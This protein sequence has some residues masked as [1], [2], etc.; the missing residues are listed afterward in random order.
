MINIDNLVRPNIRSLKPYS[1]AR[2]EYTGHE[3]IYLDA[4]EN[5]YGTWNRYP[6]P[7]QADLKKALSL[8]KNIPL[9]NIFIGNGCDEVIDLALRIF[10]TPG[11]HKVIICPPT[12][13]MYE[14][15]AHINDLEI[16][17]IPLTEEFQLNIDEILRTDATFLFL[18]SPNNPTGNHLKNIETILTRFNGIVFVDEAYIDFSDHPSL[19]SRIDRYSN[20]IVSQTLSKA[21]GHA[22]ARIGMAY[23]GK[24]IIQYFNKT[25]PPYNISSLNQKAA[26]D[27]LQHVDLY[28]ENLLKIHDAKTWLIHE[29]SALNIVSAIYPSDANFLL[30][31]MINADDIYHYLIEQKI[32]TRNR[33]NV[34]K[35][36]L[37]ITIGTPKENKTLINALKEISQ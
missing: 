25:K 9:E 33:S 17:Y 11:V 27:A 7:H 18:C 3:A 5:P 16:I 6:D 24:E 28:K 29:L 19:L 37:R 8:R 30:V 1:T 2:D 10:C 26:V 12:Y 4:N 32:I 22:A 34:V 14:V 35:D 21:W 20:L 15:A 31:E 36:C 23:S 13:G